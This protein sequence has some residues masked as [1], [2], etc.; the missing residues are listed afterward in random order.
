MPSNNNTS[1]NINQIAE[2]LWMEDPIN[3]SM[4]IPKSNIPEFK[5]V[6]PLKRSTI[7]NS[8]KKVKKVEHPK[9]V[10]KICKPKKVIQ[11]NYDTEYNNG[12]DNDYNNDYNNDYDKYY[13]NNNMNQTLRNN[14][15]EQIPQTRRSQRIVND[16]DDGYDS[17]FGNNFFNSGLNKTFRGMNNN[18]FD[19]FFF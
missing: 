12:Y 14:P 19:H 15:Y 11:N 3:E 18:L 8:P 10:K 4:I 6:T 2:D 13:S 5:K 16:D 17:F 9:K 1:L 7:E